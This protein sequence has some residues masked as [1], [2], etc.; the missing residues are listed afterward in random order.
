MLAPIVTKDMKLFPSRP[1]PAHVKNVRTRAQSLKDL[2]D[3]R[4]QQ[5]KTAQPVVKQRHA[6]STGNLNSP[7]ARSPPKGSVLAKRPLDSIAE[8]VELTSNNSGANIGAASLPPVPSS[9]KLSK[10]DANGNPQVEDEYGKLIRCPAINL[11]AK[12]SPDQELCSLQEL[13]SRPCSQ[14]STFSDPSTSN[15][16][17]K[18]TSST[19][20]IKMFT[21]ALTWPQNIR[22]K[23]RQSDYVSEKNRN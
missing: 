11:A 5:Q 10:K 12:H 20:L 9:S 6:L 17:E 13:G 8:G 19:G 1:L 2:P 15:K 4:R 16:P 3:T 21:A 22:P 18:K 23:L 7:A 14:M